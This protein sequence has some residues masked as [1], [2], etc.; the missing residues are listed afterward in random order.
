VTGKEVLYAET[1]MTR[2]MMRVLIL[3]LDFVVQIEQETQPWNQQNQ[4]KNH[5]VHQA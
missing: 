5:H 4:P 1:M 2:S 3:R